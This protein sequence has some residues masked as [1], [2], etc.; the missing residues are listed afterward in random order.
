MPDLPRGHP[1]E[2]RGGPGTTLHPPLPQRGKTS[3]LNRLHVAST[4]RSRWLSP[5][6]GAFPF[7]RFNPS[8]SEFR[9]TECREAL[10]WKCMIYSWLKTI[11]PKLIS[12]ECMEHS[13]SLSPSGFLMINDNNVSV[14]RTWKA[15]RRLD[16][17]RPHGSSETIG[18]Q[19]SRRKSADGMI[20]TEKHQ[21]TPRRQLSL[22][23]HRWYPGGL[24]PASDF[25]PTRTFKQCDVQT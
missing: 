13:E 5:H 4:L 18:C 11:W 9:P 15:A 25:S 17:G 7:I 23:K 8:M 24:V 1:E 6:K 14:S 19:V 16:Q 21:H 20:S 10:S 2:R 12:L 22:R 3:E